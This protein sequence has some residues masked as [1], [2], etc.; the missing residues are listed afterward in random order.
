MA[1]STKLV[2]AHRSSTDTIQLTPASRVTVEKGEELVTILSDDSYR[3]SPVVV[4]PIR[5]LLVNSI[6]PDSIERTPTPISHPPPHVGHHQTLSV[7]DSLKRLRV[8]KEARNTFWSLN[9][10]SLDIQ[11]VQFLPTTFDGDVFFE[12]PTIDMST[13]HFHTKLIQGMDKRHDGH[14]W[15]KTTTSHIKNDMNLKFRTSTCGSAPQHVQATSVV[16]IRIANTLPA[17]IAPL[18]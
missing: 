15:T 14:A 17:F 1:A 3:N 9:Y 8:S 12:L 18:R 6:L 10:D 16:T 11:R 2:T 4:H 5:F 7:V 13:L